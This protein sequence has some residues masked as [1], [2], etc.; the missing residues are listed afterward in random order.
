MKIGIY[1]LCLSVFVGCSIEDRIENKEDKI[2]GLWQIDKATFKEYGDLFKDNISREYRSDWFEFL[3]DYTVYYYDYEENIEY[4][5]SWEV[6]AEEGYDYHT[7]DSDVEFYL[8]MH[9][10]DPIRQDVFGYYGYIS[11]LT[12]RKFTYEVAQRTG[13]LVIHFEK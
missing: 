5:G 2:I 12:K 7:G 8:N 13:K 1:I 3:P 6:V 9:F 11:W 4:E 10:Y